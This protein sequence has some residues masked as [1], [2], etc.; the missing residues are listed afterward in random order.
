MIDPILI[1]LA[2]LIAMAAIA[3]CLLTRTLR[4]MEKRK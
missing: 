4:Q 1:I 2:L 3:D